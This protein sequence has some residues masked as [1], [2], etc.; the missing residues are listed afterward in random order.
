[1][2]EII[3]ATASGITEGI[4]SGLRPKNYIEHS[5]EK[6]ILEI[7]GEYTSN[8]LNTSI[9]IGQGAMIRATGGARIIQ[10]D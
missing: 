10:R 8:T 4:I 2:E 5:S 1:M 7:S 6:G 3:K 9:R